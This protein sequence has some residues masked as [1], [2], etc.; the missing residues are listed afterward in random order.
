MTNVKMIPMNISPTLM[1]MKKSSIS[2]LKTLYLV[3]ANWTKSK[4]AM[5]QKTISIAMNVSKSLVE[6]CCS[7]KFKRLEV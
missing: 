4:E 1:T 7:S 5:L 2:L 3:G 6:L